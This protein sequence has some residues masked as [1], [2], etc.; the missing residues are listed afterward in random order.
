MTVSLVR[1]ESLHKPVEIATDNTN[2]INE[3]SV[4]DVTARVEEL[5]Q[6]TLTNNEGNYKLTRYY[7]KWS[8]HS[9]ASA[10]GFKKLS[11]SF[12]D[13]SFSDKHIDSDL[14]DNDD[15]CVDVDFDLQALPAY[16]LSR[17]G[18]VVQRFSGVVNEALKNA[19]E[20]A[21]SDANTITVN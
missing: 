12:M 7:S 17:N 3:S 13:V 14:S 15:D 10:E 1:R 8:P 20:E 16:I 6:E 5:A 11:K 9:I 19:I 4:Q 2:V 18:E 21:I